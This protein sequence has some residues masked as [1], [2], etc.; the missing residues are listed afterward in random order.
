MFTYDY[1]LSVYQHPLNYYAALDG[2]LHLHGGS[3]CEP[4]RKVAQ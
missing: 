2:E 4:Y 1:V 3:L